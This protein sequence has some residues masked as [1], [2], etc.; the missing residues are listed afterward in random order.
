[1]ALKRSGRS[2]DLYKFLQKP[3]PAPAPTGSQ[4]IKRLLLGGSHCGS[5]E[6]NPTSINED[7]GS[8]PGLA[9]WVKDPA[10]S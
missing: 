5:V 6:T 8:L 10:L 2:Q 9:L 3:P 1:M 4:N 7:E